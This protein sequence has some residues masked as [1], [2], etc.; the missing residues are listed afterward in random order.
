MP[1][2]SDEPKATD[3]TAPKIRRSAC[4]LHKS[5]MREAATCSR[6]KPKSVTTPKSSYGVFDNQG[7]LW[8]R[9]IGETRMEARASLKD[10]A[11][12]GVWPVAR[13]NGFTIRKIKIAEV[14]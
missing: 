10:P 11:G 3:T 5:I 12:I 13:K 4:N 7:D 9:T 14:K 2:P 6:M 8:H 1:K